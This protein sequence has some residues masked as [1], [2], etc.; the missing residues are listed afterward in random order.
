MGSY[1]EGSIFWILSGVWVPRGLLGR[2]DPSRCVRAWWRHGA[3]G[4]V[5]MTSIVG[6]AEVRVRSEGR[7]FAESSGVLDSGSPAIMG[8]SWPNPAMPFLRCCAVSCS[9]S[10]VLVPWCSLMWK[11]CVGAFFL[12]WEP[13][14]CGSSLGVP[15]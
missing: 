8:I 11:A 6:C 4:F 12:L 14:K 7:V 5:G 3:L 9:H 13:C 1:W 15:W 10:V 2:L